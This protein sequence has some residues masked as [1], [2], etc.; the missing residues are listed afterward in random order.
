MKKL[1]VIAALALGVLGCSKTE[2]E[3]TDVFDWTDKDAIAPVS[4]DSETGVD[5]FSWDD[6]REI[7]PGLLEQNGITL[8]KHP[9]AGG[10]PWEGAVVINDKAVI[11]DVVKESGLESR[12]PGG[13]EDYSLL[14]GYALTGH[15]GGYKISQR[16]KRALDGVSLG[17]LIEQVGLG[18]CTPG[19]AFYM[20]L[21]PKL[22]AGPVSKIYR[23]DVA[24]D[25]GSGDSAE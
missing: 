5:L 20:A 8:S 16:V 9:G 2:M 18:M 10:I 3:D 22:P 23:T 1:F 7:V 19:Y 15:T 6:C 11:N 14:V 24:A 17:L 12:I 4:F 21:Y 25:S 13:I